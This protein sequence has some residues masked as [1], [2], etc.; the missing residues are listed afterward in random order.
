[1]HGPSTAYRYAQGRIAPTLASSRADHQ[2][3]DE[4]LTASHAAQL[5]H[6]STAIDSLSTC[7]QPVA[8][9]QLQLE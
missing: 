5:Q 2:L 3:P 6:Q 1:M 9:S 7:P 8:S 4:P